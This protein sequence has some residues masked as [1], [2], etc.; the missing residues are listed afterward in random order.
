MSLGAAPVV[1]AE[2]TSIRCLVRVP[3]TSPVK[4]YP[5]WQNWHRRP[6]GVVVT[7]P[8]APIEPAA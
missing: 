2:V 3:V 1:F 4:G 6:A 5:T 7:K 8:I